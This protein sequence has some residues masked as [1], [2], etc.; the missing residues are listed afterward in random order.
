MAGALDVCAAQ[1]VGLLGALVELCGDAERD[2]ERDGGERVQQQRRD[3]AVQAGARDRLAAA[4]GRG[5]DRLVLAEILGDGRPAAVVVSDGHAL[6]TAC[7]DDEALQ[8]RGSFARRAGASLAT[9]RLG[10]GEQQSLVGLELGE[11][12]V[13]GVGVGDQRGPLIAGEL[14][15]ADLA[16][17]V[18]RLAAAE[19]ERAGVARVVQHHQHPVVVKRR[20][21]GLALAGAGA[22][23]L[24]EGQLAC[25]ELLDHG[26]RRAGPLEAFEQ[27]TDRALDGRVGIECHLSERVVDQAGR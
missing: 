24:R 5:V 22:D 6:A 27:V 12:D 8:Q 23:S 20:P 18:L 25:G 21:D 3:R 2:F 11:A 17:Q 13:S 10:V 16:G 19:G 14:P 26:A 1:R 15:D 7:A 4:A 9:A